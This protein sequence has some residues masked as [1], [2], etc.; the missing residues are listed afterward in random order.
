M[1]RK[2]LSSLRKQS[3]V[4]KRPTS[5][6]DIMEVFGYE[7]FAPY[8]SFSV[9][10]DQGYPALNISESDFEILITAELPGL[11][12]K[13]VEIT[14][15]DDVLFIKGEKKFEEEKN[16]HRI[17]RSYGMFQ[18][19]ITLPCSVKAEKIR[20]SFDKGVM[21]VTIMKSEK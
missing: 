16:Y 11:E 2:F 5:I 18:R 20:A 12:P 3:L 10:R 13:D 6:V 1:L 9:L 14:V 21:T 4:T 17:E 19:S 8:P 15:A 7:P